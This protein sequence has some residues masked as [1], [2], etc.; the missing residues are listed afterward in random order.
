M[1]DEL[2]MQLFS[3]EREVSEAARLALIDSGYDAVEPLIKYVRTPDPRRRMRVLDVLGTLA[4][5]RSTKAI[6]SSMTDDHNTDVRVAAAL[7]LIAI[8]DTAA[9]DALFL[10]LR[11]LMP[12]VKSAAIR[13]VGAYGVQSAVPHL[14][15]LMKSESEEHVA[16]LVRTESVVYESALVLGEQF[17]VPEV[18]SFWLE[19]LGKGESEHLLDAIRVLGILRSAAAVDMLLGNLHAPDAATRVAAAEALGQ[20]GAA[21]AVDP[22]LLALARDTAGDVR[23]ACA[24]ALGHLHDRYA[25]EPLKDA[26]QD[27]DHAVQL[28]AVT[29]LGQL[30]GED[31]VVALLTV[32]QGDTLPQTRSAIARA[33][34]H[35]GDPAGT[36]ALELLLLNDGDYNVQYS[37]ALGLAD[38]ANPRAIEVLRAG[39]RQD[40]PLLQQAAARGLGLVRDAHAAPA[41]YELLQS[42]ERGVRHAAAIALMQIDADYAQDGFS[43]LVADLFHGDYEVCWF[44]L[45]SLQEYP[46]PRFLKPLEAV[47]A[48]SD[49]NTR[50]L[51][52]EVLGA[53]GSTAAIQH[54]VPHLQDTD[55]AVRRA[56][57]MA[58]IK[59][60]YFVS[61]L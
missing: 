47:L 22:L 59:L 40:N 23:A 8:D 3:P 45:R 57:R 17:Q 28:A 12:Q 29:A 30:G 54:L 1:F 53:I 31:V 26:L 10:A 35:L 49:G 15:R 5:V 48:D 38:L 9:L 56:A 37:A 58:L 4:D 50:A 32:L 46:H 27:S 60:G 44:T 42:P 13:V 16:G 18:E 19:A 34:G 36:R 55:W 33:L 21:A 7:T 41:I 20:I 11:D 39:L 52:A 25:V 24:E 14:L 51:A 6:A 61:K 43:T 2:I